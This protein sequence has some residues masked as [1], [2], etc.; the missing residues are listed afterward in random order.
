M[1][2]SRAA[3]GQPILSAGG[4]LEAQVAAAAALEGEVNR[5]ATIV[6]DDRA[7]SPGA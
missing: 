5:S 2:P 6:V 3:P 7:A 1:V 4:Q